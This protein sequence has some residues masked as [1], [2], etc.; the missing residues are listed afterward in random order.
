M[1]NSIGA[2]LGRLLLHQLFG[3]IFLYYYFFF[4]TFFCIFEKK[5]IV[6]KIMPR[7]VGDVENN[8][9]AIVILW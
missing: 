6:W 3:A 8:L 2:L 4:L 1:G 9:Y 5:Y 7:N